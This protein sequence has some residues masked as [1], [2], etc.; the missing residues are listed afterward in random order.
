MVELGRRHA[1]YEFHKVVEL[2]HLALVVTYVNGLHA[3]GGVALL[4]VYLADNLILLAVHV[5]I[6]HALSAEAIL[7]CLGNVAYAC[8][9]TASFVAVDV[10]PYLG[11]AELEVHV[12]HLEG[13]V[14]VYAAQELRQHLL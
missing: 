3:C 14:V 11:A 7:Q 8:A 5:E 12:G 1:L 10:H 13:G 2:D 4:A 6:A 9:H